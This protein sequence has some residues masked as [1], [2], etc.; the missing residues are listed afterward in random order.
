MF[1]IKRDYYDGTKTILKQLN[2]NKYYTFDKVYIDVINQIVKIDDDTVFYDVHH[3]IIS[4]LIHA[5]Y[6]IKSIEYVIFNSKGGL[7]E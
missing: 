2:G 4:E 5:C 6:G 7:N 3:N 1:T